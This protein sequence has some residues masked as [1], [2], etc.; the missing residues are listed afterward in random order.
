MPLRCRAIATLLAACLGGLLL[1]PRGQATGESAREEL[2]LA[3]AFSRTAARATAQI[4]ASVVSV[5]A[6]AAGREEYGSAVIVDA[7]GLALTALHVVAGSNSVAVVTR[8]GEEFPARVTGRDVALDLALIEILAPGRRFPEATLADEGEQKLGESVLVVGNPFGL[9]G[10]VSLGVLAGRGRTGIVTGCS[11]PMLQTDAA[12]NPGC[13]GGALGNLRGEVIGLVDAI[14]T[15]DGRSHGIGFA[16]PA[17]ELS[18]ALPFLA[19]GL[20]VSRPWIGLLLLPVAGIE[21]GLAV[22]SVV[23]AGPGEKAGVRVGDILLR[24]GGRRVGGLDELRRALRQTKPGESLSVGLRRGE[25]LLTLELVVEER[26]GP[27]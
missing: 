1:A 17:S 16:I 20:P 14:L 19:K 21:E 5:R 23:A 7:R 27:H 9:G 25:S 10:S 3:L 12:I 8:D 11:A 4:G 24:L 26:A 2:D 13:S 22:S 15:R 6:F 18:Y